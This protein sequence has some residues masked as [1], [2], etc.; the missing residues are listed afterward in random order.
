[1]FWGK[2]NL[3][4]PQ[5]AGPLQSGYIK[6]TDY[7]CSCGLLRLLLLPLSDTGIPPCT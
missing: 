1:M 2:S 3:N 6:V 7:N 5:G 4:R